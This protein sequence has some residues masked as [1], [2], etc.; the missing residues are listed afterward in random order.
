MFKV[1][2]RG[3]NNFIARVVALVRDEL[4]MD[5][6]PEFHVREPSSGRHVSITL[7]P[8]VRDAE[9]VQAIYR[10]LIEVEGLVMLL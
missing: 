3:D 1:I 4:S 9:Q 6:D 2:G 10:R 8:P 5:F 7:E